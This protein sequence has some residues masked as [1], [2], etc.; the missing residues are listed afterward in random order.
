MTQSGTIAGT[1]MYMSP[2][3]AHSNH[4]DQRSDLFS[5]GSVL[6]EMVSG[7]PPFR[8][9]STL[10]VLKRVTEDT[11]R[12]IQEIIPES[13]RLAVYDHFQAARQACRGSL[14]NRQRSRRTAR[15]LPIRAAAC[16]ES[17]V[18]SKSAITLRVKS[19]QQRRPP[20]ALHTSPNAVAQPSAAP[21]GSSRRSE[22]ATLKRP[23]LIAASIIGTVAII[24][25]LM[26]NRFNNSTNP[27]SGGRQPSEP[28]AESSIPESEISNVE[29]EI[30]NPVPEIAN[31]TPTD[32]DRRAAEYVLSIGGGISIKD[33]GSG[34]SR[35]RLS[36]ICPLGAF[37]LTAVNLIETR[38]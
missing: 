19:L 20:A 4:I 23:R 28:I 37:E 15:P 18:R 11:P 38:R 21:Q 6:Y 32:P 12:P 34:T 16:R 3:Q 24:A 29:S 30:S 9:A 2:E 10:A 22:T 26:L 13:P 36:A 7:R 25:I 5:L 8:A 33:R 1:P 27:A 14:S 31:G 17:D 35:S